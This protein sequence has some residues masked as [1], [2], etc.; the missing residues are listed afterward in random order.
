MIFFIYHDFTTL[1]SLL[2]LKTHTEALPAE[3]RR[4]VPISKFSTFK[5][6]T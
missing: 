5:N 2:K 3:T 6:E 1:Q 4:P